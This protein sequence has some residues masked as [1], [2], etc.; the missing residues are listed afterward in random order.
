MEYYKLNLNIIYWPYI[1][2][3]KKVNINSIE[4]SLSREDDERFR[5]CLSILYLVLWLMLKLFRTF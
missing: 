1:A 4:N 2:F 3:F 5:L